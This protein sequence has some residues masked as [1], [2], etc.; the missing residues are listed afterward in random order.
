MR[1]Y[2]LAFVACCVGLFGCAPAG[3]LPP[4]PAPQVQPLFAVAL[5]YSDPAP[6]R[7]EVT[8]SG[9]SGTETLYV[10]N[11]DVITLADVQSVQ[12]TTL[13]TEDALRFVL[14]PDGGDRMSRATG[15]HIG[16]RMAIFVDGSLHSAPSVQ[17][18][19]DKGEFYV[20][21]G[22]L[23]EAKWKTLEA[24]LAQALGL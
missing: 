5:A 10:L 12:F 18:P 13:D 6:G 22:G 1:L 11:T 20:T 19:I 21:G 9:S 16:G 23:T 15:G 14:K 8:L 4:P 3:R 17:Q 24:K 7:K 2:P